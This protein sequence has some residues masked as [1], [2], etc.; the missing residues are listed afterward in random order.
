M[1][2]TRTDHNE[3][4]WLKHIIEWFESLPQPLDEIQQ[5]EYN[6]YKKRLSYFNK[7]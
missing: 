4:K 3:I 1:V 5:K 2:I 6:S 7:S